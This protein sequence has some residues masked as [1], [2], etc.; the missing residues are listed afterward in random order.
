MFQIGEFEVSTE[1][2]C[3][4]SESSRWRRSGCVSDRGVRGGDRV[5]V[6]QIGEFEVVTEWVCSRSESSRW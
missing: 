6:F 3:S 1:W 2:V 4:R 5:G